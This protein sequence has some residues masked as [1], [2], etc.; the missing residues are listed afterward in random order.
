MLM[1]DEEILK[2]VASKAAIELSLEEADTVQRLVA[3]SPALRDQFARRLALQTYLADLQL[4]LEAQR[5]AAAVAEVRGGTGRP[6]AIDAASLPWGQI[7]PIVCGLVVL[8]GLLWGSWTTW[9]RI[10]GPTVSFDREGNS[11]ASLA[12]DSSDRLNRNQTAE[13][14]ESV[15][16]SALHSAQSSKGPTVEAGRGGPS[17]DSRAAVV[18]PG[19]HPSTAAEPHAGS[20]DQTAAGQSASS[21]GPRPVP[22]PMSKL[23]AAVPDPSGEGG[24]TTQPVERSAQAGGKDGAR[25]ETVSRP[26]SGSSPPAAAVAAGGKPAGAGA[27]APAPAASSLASVGPRSASSGSGQRPAESAV[28]SPSSAKPSES[29]ANMAANAPTEVTSR[30]APSAYRDPLPIRPEDH[31]GKPWHDRLGDSHSPPAFDTVCFEQFDPQRDLPTRAQLADWFDV[32]VGNPQGLVEVRTRM[33]LGG[34]I[35][36]LV[37]LKAPWTDDSVWRF[38]LESYNRLQLHFFRGDTGVTLVYQEPLL[39]QWTAYQ[40]TRQ[41]PGFTPISH[42]LVATDAGRNLRSEIQRGGAYELRVRAGDLLLSR[43]DLLLLRVALGGPPEDVLLQGK[44]TILGIAWLRTSQEER[45]LSAVGSATI[46]TRFPT[47]SLGAGSVG[48]SRATPS[49]V[50]AGVA[51]GAPNQPAADDIL[52][53]ASPSSS[54]RMSAKR[55]RFAAEWVANVSEGVEWSREADT[56]RSSQPASSGESAAGAPS[57]DA[58]ATPSPATSSPATSSPATPSP[59]TPSPATSELAA[60]DSSG[61]RLVARRAAKRSWVISRRVMNRP[62][63]W[64]FEVDGVT[65]GAGIFLGS[66]KGPRTILRYVIDRRTNQLCLHARGDDDA[67]QH[68]FPPLDERPLPTVAP[69]HWV[70]LIFSGEAVRWWVSP[71]GERWVEPGEPIRLPASEL[72][73]LGLHCVSQQECGITLRGCY[74]EPFEGIAALAADELLTAATPPTGV[75]DMAAWQAAVDPTRP[76]ECA[77][78]AWRRAVAVRTLAIGCPRSLAWPLVDFLTNEAQRL[79]WSRQ[80]QFLLLDQAACLLDL[81][82]D[83]TTLQQ[84]VGRYHQAAWAT[85]G[86]VTTPRTAALPLPDETAAVAAPTAPSSGAA[87][88][89]VPAPAAQVSAAP[90]SVPSA[91][92]AAVNNP[93]QPPTQANAQSVAASSR[94]EP[95]PSAPSTPVPPASEPRS[96]EAPLAAAQPLGAEVATTAAG[97]PNKEHQPGAPAALGMRAG[98]SILSDAR[99]PYTAARLALS[100]SPLLTRRTFPSST[101]RLIRGELLLLL[102]AGDWLAVEQSCQSVRFFHL[103]EQAPLN[104]WALYQVEQRRGSARQ[105]G[106]GGV[107]GAILKRPPDNW[108]PVVVEQL[109]KDTFNLAAELQAL[110]ESEAWEDAARRATSLDLA[111]LSGLTPSYRDPQLLVAAPL[112]L[113]QL[114]R[115]YPQ[116]KQAIVTHHPALANLRLTEAIRAADEQ[117]VASAAVLFPNTPAADRAYRWLAERALVAG[118]FSEARQFVVAAALGH[119]S[120]KSQAVIASQTPSAGLA[121]GANPGPVTNRPIAPTEASGTGSRPAT[122]ESG[123]T[124]PELLTVTKRWNWPVE[125]AELLTKALEEAPSAKYGPQ[126]FW[127]PHREP[128]APTPLTLAARLPLAGPVGRDPEKFVQP[129]ISRLQVDWAGR[130]WSCALTDNLLVVNNRFHLAAFDLQTRELRWQ[131]TPPQGKVLGGQDWSL[132]AMRPLIVGERIFARQLYTDGGLLVCLNRETG[133]TYWVS[134]PYS[135]F[136]LISDP[137]WLQDALVC[138]TLA[139]VE[140]GESVVSWTRFDPQTGAVWSERELFRVNDVWFQR[141]YCEVQPVGR[142]FV[143]ALGGTLIC[144]TATGELR[145]MRQQLA[146]PPDEDPEWVQQLFAPP[147]VVD[148]Q[149]YLIQ[150]GV[151]EVICVDLNTGELQWSRPE[152]EL[153]RCLGVRG[154]KLIVVS[155]NHLLALDRR[156][157]QER[158]RQETGELLEGALC[159]GEHGLVTVELGEVNAQTKERNTQLVWRHAESGAVVQSVPL[160]ELTGSETRCGPL[161]GFQNQIWM[162][163]GKGFNSPVRELISWQ[164]AP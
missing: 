74:H 12:S 16:K 61:I 103:T 51:V 67:W 64:L 39:H 5:Q 20:P 122:S 27:E 19:N 156:T 11:P 128:P 141:S 96:V 99:R 66:E 150:P 88:P 144:C 148:Q 94:A 102:N 91:S 79:G 56:P 62:A 25:Q 33:G 3:A 48:P 153:R 41:Q 127:G 58:P 15:S 69:R 152:P 18:A 130:Q 17:V 114:Q 2:L 101:P 76:A 21:P 155:G 45:L 32:L 108:R 30:E 81:Y 100:S 72:T 162:I 87:A 38:S 151:W 53:A 71:D 92:P 26:G 107:P 163:A 85:A 49:G 117:A 55:T 73:H 142:Y 23:P 157:G 113:E 6:R 140:Q 42:Q 31:V 149:M 36:G 134:K 118:R 7:I 59:A 137:V 105:A 50:E 82:D 43:G 145:W 129:A 147:L 22:T 160:M 161:F 146:T 143:A 106:S 116:F 68:D 83:Q 13:P 119:A 97:L 35:D 84:L 93:S 44:A 110:L 159:G 70:R 47:L 29:S 133:Q 77:P 125:M 132:T 123:G 111:T 86:A 90:A 40:T 121:S 65:P 37:R 8:L 98:D 136:R 57:V 126:G 115:E 131:S 139:R 4:R 54:F 14:A 24:A 158:W 135:N 109:G 1:T 60:G 10:E 63:A 154:E 34:A 52:A 95:P 28:T 104:A 9:Q 80:Q 46:P 120:V 75:A 112:M 78:D 89:T 138:L 164:P 124:D